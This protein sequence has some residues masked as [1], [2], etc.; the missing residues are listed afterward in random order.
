MAG[1]DVYLF[2]L[3]IRWRKAMTPLRWEMGNGFL[4]CCSL[5]KQGS[6]VC[7][8]LTLWQSSWFQIRKHVSSSSSPSNDAGPVVVLSTRSTWDCV[9]LFNVGNYCHSIEEKWKLRNIWE[10]EVLGAV[11]AL[12]HLLAVQDCSFSDSNCFSLKWTRKTT[13]SHTPV[14]QCHRLSSTFLSISTEY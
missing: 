8:V 2:F 3:K 5:S 10:R 4:C 9:M 12:C 6:G 14:K 11:F 13:S 1:Y 7:V